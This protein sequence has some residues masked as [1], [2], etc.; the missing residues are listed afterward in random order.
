MCNPAYSFDLAPCW[1]KIKNRLP[2]QRLLS[3]EETIEEYEKHVSEVTKEDPIPSITHSISFQ[4]T[5]NA[6]MILL[7]L[8]VSMGGDDHLLFDSSPA[9]LPLEYG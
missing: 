8:L 4:E 7:G 9:R 2:S 3:P 5:D 6:L 1:H